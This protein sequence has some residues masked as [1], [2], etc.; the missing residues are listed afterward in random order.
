[1][2]LLLIIV[3]KYLTALK[4]LIDLTIIYENLT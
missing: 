4:L 1:M 2:E 3:F